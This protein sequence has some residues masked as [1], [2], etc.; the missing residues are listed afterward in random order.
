MDLRFE[1]LTAELLMQFPMIFLESQI[2]QM[3]GCLEAGPYIA[4]SSVF[5]PYLVELAPGPDV[6]TKRKVATLLEKLASSRDSAV[7]NLLMIEVVP[8]ILKKQETVDAYWPLLGPMTRRKLWEAYPTTAPDIVLPL[9]GEE[10][11]GRFV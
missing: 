11:K 7:V 4:Y 5:T 1:R 3:D 8:H 9:K 6:W 2:V 10:F